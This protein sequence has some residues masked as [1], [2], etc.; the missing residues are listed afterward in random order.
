MIILSII[1]L[2]FKFPNPLNLLVL[3]SSLAKIGGRTKFRVFNSWDIMRRCYLRCAAITFW[4]TVK[5][6]L[7]R[8]LESRRV[9]S[10]IIQ[11]VRRNNFSGC[12]IKK[13]CFCSR[14]KH[15]PVSIGI[16]LYIYVP[17]ESLPKIP[18]LLYLP[19][20]PP[21]RPINPRPNQRPREDHG[22]HQGSQRESKIS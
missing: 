7:A 9:Y 10:N 4:N 17:F 21:R 16:K 1:S 22:E 3:V 12:D 11:L 13:H 19:L 18:G 6:N 5:L 8:Q 14:Q 15:D 20:Q 2:N